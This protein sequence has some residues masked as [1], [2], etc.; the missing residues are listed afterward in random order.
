MLSFER[1]A[2]I[3]VVSGDTVEV[4]SGFR[5]ASD[6]VMT[7]SHLL[8]KTEGKSRQVIVVF[9]ATGY[10][11]TGELVWNGDG[12]GLDCALIRIDPASD[13]EFD[14]E[15]RTRWGK[16]TG[17]DPG[18]GGTAIG[19]PRTMREDT[20]MRQPDQVS[21]TLNPGALFGRRYDLNVSSASPPLRSKGVS[22]WSGLSGAALFSS[23]YL[24]GVVVRDEP[25][26]GSRRISSVP[27]STLLAEPSFREIGRAHV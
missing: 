8:Q 23:A 12:F 22:L 11:A 10:K 6:L 5:I 2:Q 15:Y 1:V 26:F 17:T 4:G 19:F 24:I 18:I 16:L 13:R 3:R 27:S 20:G 7:A 14:D 21:G 25:N 9:A